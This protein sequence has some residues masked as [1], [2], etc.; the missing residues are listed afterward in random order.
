MLHY[1]AWACDGLRRPSAHSWEVVVRETPTLSQLPAP[2]S[3]TAR[4]IG[5]RTRGRKASEMKMRSLNAMFGLAT[6]TMLACSSAPPPPSGAA[7]TPGQGS[8]GGAAGSAGSAGT[9]GSGV[10]G[11]TVGAAGAAGTAGTTGAAG[12]AGSTGIAGSGADAGVD[13]G[14]SVCA[15]GAAGATGAGGT[16]PCPTGVLGHC[17]ATTAMAPTHAG[18]TLALAE[19][20]DDTID[21]DTDPIWTWSDG[22]PEDGQ[23]R[24]RKSQI[25]FAGGKM[26][27]TA[28]S[29]CA[30]GTNNTKCIPGGDVTYAEPVL[31]MK[32]GTIAAMGVWSGEMRTKYNNYR[33][34]WYEAKF[35]APIAV[36]NMQTV[37]NAGDF[38]STLFIFRS[39]KWQEWNEI[40]IELEPNN[41]S[42]LQGNVVNATGRTSYPGDRANPINT[43][44]GLPAMYNITDEH[45]YAFEWT[46]TSVTWYVD[47]VQSQK[48]MG[49]ANDPIPSKSGKIM[50][51]LWVFDG[52]TFG[53]GSLNKFPFTSE[54]EYFHFY[55]SDAE[56]T[57]TPKYPCSPTPTCLPATDLDYA[58][59]NASEMNYAGP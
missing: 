41:P 45:V 27:I 40:D 56:A 58:Q 50:M 59:N 10:A 54:Y 38:L 5:F 15:A 28:D 14:G 21:L 30:A 52:A 4:E 46:P 32:T 47:G 39:P 42:H 53:T 35:H 34:G 1:T 8:A 22:S 25:A 7:G 23:T 6:A 3:L 17:N 9:S 49:S 43:T 11:S 48:F 55:V 26:T 24:F 44:T 16:T 29:P 37:A 57:Q 19:E 20:F 2:P 33:Y 31:N 36:P 13:A 51:N 18:Y 12:A